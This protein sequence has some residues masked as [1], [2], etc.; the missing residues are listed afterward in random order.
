[1]PGTT[2]DAGERC[3]QPDRES[4]RLEAIDTSTRDE[5][6]LEELEG[7]L[8]SA[9]GELG[10][11]GG[12]GKLGEILELE[13]GKTDRLNEMLGLEHRKVRALEEISACL[14]AFLGEGKRR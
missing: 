13:K 1:M 7:Q 4:E 11:L 3:D 12:A 14:N 9:L 5:A 8:K 6:K 2:D 10:E